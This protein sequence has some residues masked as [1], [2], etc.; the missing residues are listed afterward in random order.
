MK[1]VIS[2][3]RLKKLSTIWI[4]ALAINAA[5]AQ[6]FPHAALGDGPN[7]ICGAVLTDANLRPKTGDKYK[8]KMVEMNSWMAEK[9]KIRGVIYLSPE[10]REQ[11]R[12][13][14]KDGIVYDVHGNVFP[15]TVNTKNNV[16]NYVMDASGNFYLFDENTTPKIRHSSIFDGGPIAGAGNITIKGGKIVLLDSDSGHYPSK[17]LF[18]NVL[19]ELAADGVDT[20]GFK[21]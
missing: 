4:C 1:A 11:R 14:I 18:P 3:S 17:P 21:P 8:D 20:T 15:D 9:D 10:Q 6:A 12:V 13:V 5:I 19:A 7:P 2:F 16:Q